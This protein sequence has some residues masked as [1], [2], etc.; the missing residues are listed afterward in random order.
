ME[1]WPEDTSEALKPYRTRKDELTVEG[2]C[3]LWGIRVIVP[4]KLQPRMLEELH[5]DHPGASRMKALARN[6]MWWP[7]LDN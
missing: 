7:G 6:Y 3:L 5:R 4:K 1:G 2:E